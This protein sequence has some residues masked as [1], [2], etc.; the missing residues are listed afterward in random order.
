MAQKEITFWGHYSSLV[1]L[2]LKSMMSKTV[3][4]ENAMECKAPFKEGKLN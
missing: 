1:C 3:V 4:I 2:T